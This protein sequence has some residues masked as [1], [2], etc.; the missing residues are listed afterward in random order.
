MATLDAVTALW[1]DW[2]RPMVWQTALLFLAAWLLDRLLG[3]RLW[4]R[5]RLTLWTVLLLKLILPPD[6]T[7]PWSLLS[8]QEPPA[9]A[10]FQ[11]AGSSQKVQALPPS[12]IHPALAAAWARSRPAAEASL[13]WR[14]LAGRG[15]FCLW[16]LGVLLVAA[17]RLRSWHRMRRLRR[18]G[19]KE[20]VPASVLRD[21][22]RAA[23]L[24]GL[25]RLP[26]IILD[27]RVRTP[28]VT[29]LLRPC[30]VIP[31]GWAQGS[32][33][34]LGVALLHE[35]AH[36][37]RKDLWLRAAA[38]LLANLYWFHP[39]VHLMS[40]RLE[41]LSEVCCDG[42]VVRA[43][44][45]QADGYRQALLQA[46][47]ELLEGPS[48]RPSWLHAG[49]QGSSSLLLQRLKGLERL[50]GAPFH[51]QRLVAVLLALSMVLTVLPMGATPDS[52]AALP[53]AR[54][55]GKGLSGPV[56]ADQQAR[57]VLR[58]AARGERQGC[59]RL[60]WAAQSLIAAGQGGQDGDSI[61]SE[62]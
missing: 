27:D 39:A 57:Q 11:Q 19:A 18:E 1:M 25:R 22:R 28:L 56:P 15:L 41:A 37:R 24:M 34:R 21:A 46:A 59:L 49:W 61:P 36:L 12:G 50:P 44:P 14:R 43:V 2:M 26:R 6:L 5:L 30:I 9:A 23:S 38:S 3:P 20:A 32:P 33:R 4:P 62:P 31:R 60:R 13:D 17:L 53:A 40:R 8:W 45:E 42:T 51:L 55:A 52:A 10:V 58:R 47:R 48:E 16:A 7:S 35:M 29:G 54:P